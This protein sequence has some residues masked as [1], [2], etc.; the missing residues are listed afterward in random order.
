MRLILTGLKKLQVVEND[1]VQPPEHPD[2]VLTDVLCCAVCRTDAKMWEQGHRDLVFP[3]VLGH[4]MV[5]QDE[6]KQRYAVWPGKSCGTCKFC[7]DGRENL[8]EHMKITGFHNDGGFAD[9]VILPKKSLIPIPDTMNP[10]LACFAEPVACVVNAFEKLQIISGQ[11]MLIYG[12]GTMGLITALYAKEQGMD[13]HILEKNQTKIDHIQHF[14]GPF[15]LT[16]SKEIQDSEYDIVINC[17]ADFIA[18][19]QS[20]TKVQK[21]GQISF[22]SGITKNEQIE[23]NLLNLL[24]YKEAT[25]TGVYGMTRAHIKTAIPFISNHGRALKQLIQ[26][27]VTPEQL[28]DL[29]PVVLTGNHLKYIVDMTIH[30]ADSHD[31]SQKQ[32]IEMDSPSLQPQ[33]SEA[34]K[35]E[36]LFQSISS[37]IQPLPDT[38]MANATTKMDDKTKPLGALGRLEPLAIRMSQ[39]QETLNPKIQTR[40]L[41]VFAGDHGVTEEGVSAYPSEVTGQMVKNFLN[42]GAAINVL[43]RH[44]NIDMKV[45]DMGVKTIFNP[46]PDLIIKKVARGTNNFALENAMSRT[47]AIQ[48]LENGMATFLDAYNTEPIDIVG[49]GEMGIGNTTAASCIICAAT[50]LTPDQATGRGTG[51]DDKGLEHKTKVIKKVLNFHALGQTNCQPGGQIDGFE[52]LQKIGGFEIAGIAGAVLAAA[53]K[54]TAIVLDGVISTAAG[55]IA[56]LIN[57]AVQ[58]YLISGHQSV[59]ISHRAAL[60]FME[61][62]PLLD[63]NMRLGEGTGAALAIDMAQASCKIMSEMASFDDAKIARSL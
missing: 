17:C 50:G 25:L 4:E 28:P 59:E 18:F 48:A 42:G 60:E 35:T 3:R 57:P 8:C 9:Q 63:L 1:M 24:H 32:T 55:L 40:Q 31:D 38:L 44:H 19:S 30:P 15:G 11:R 14:I 39:I 52:I 53:S 56:F 54:K 20:I 36:G 2:N 41:F 26:K 49:L 6:K 21:A 43:C 34:K 27:I 23:T 7:I 62:E 47:Q 29:I 61:L 16:C 51:V 37:G 12:A 5:V 10:H 13:V 45:V 33:A 46:H 22:F 58:G